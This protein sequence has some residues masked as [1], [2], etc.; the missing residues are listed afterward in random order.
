M[1]VMKAWKP[2]KAYPKGSR[3]AE[4]NDMR[5]W[6]VY[7]ETPKAGFAH[8]SVGMQSRNLRSACSWLTTLASA[9][10]Y[11]SVISHH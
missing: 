5:I 1:E 11:R 9:Q 10:S 4:D 8:G 6:R 2:N 3:R 7:I